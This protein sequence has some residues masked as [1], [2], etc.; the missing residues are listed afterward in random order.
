[1]KKVLICLF[2]GFTAAIILS[3]IAGSMIALI[4]L[5]EDRKYDPLMFFGFI[6]VGLSFAFYMGGDSQDENNGDKTNHDEKG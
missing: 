4:F 1:M 6:G 3:I 5:V 2:Y